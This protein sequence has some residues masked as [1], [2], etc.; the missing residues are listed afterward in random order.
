VGLERHAQSGDFGLPEHDPFCG[1]GL[2]SMFLEQLVDAVEDG[3]AVLDD[4]Q[5]LV[6]EGFGEDPVV[7]DIGVVFEQFEDDLEL[8][9]LPRDGRQVGAR[10]ATA[11]DKSGNAQQRFPRSTQ[12]SQRG[13]CNGQ[14]IHIPCGLAGY[15]CEALWQGARRQSNSKMRDIGDAGLPFKLP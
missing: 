15:N 5:D 8:S 11:T 12:K 14:W 13:R 1:P 4:G 10:I 6:L 9:K 3:G 2:A 7:A